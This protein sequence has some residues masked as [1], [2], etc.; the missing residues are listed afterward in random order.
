MER[1]TLRLATET[2]L[3]ALWAVHVAGMRASIEQTWGWD[4]TW[5]ATH[6]RANFPFGNRQVVQWNGALAGYLDVDQSP[7]RIYLANI[8]LS[9]AFHNLGIGTSIIADLQSRA[10]EAN[11]PLELQV[12]HVN[13]N[14]HRLYTRFGFGQYG[15]TETHHLMR[16]Q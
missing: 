7:E 15:S 4:H 16:W 9:P 8:V 2:D 13:V 14:A 12:L 11:L 1:V 6:F 10:R 3:T 5:Q